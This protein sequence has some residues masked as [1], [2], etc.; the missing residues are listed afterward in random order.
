MSTVPFPRGHSGRCVKLTARLNLIPR[1]R[2]CEDINYPPLYDFLA[3]IGTS[4]LPKNL[5]TSVDY[6]PK[7]INR[8]IFV[9]YDCVLC[10]V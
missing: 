7:S 1:L 9:M 10:D 2:M 6:F 8:F 5:R 4:L 3:W